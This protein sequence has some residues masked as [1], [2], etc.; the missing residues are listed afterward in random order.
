ME[1]YNPTTKSIY[2]FLIQYP[3][4]YQIILYMKIFPFASLA[5]L[6]LLPFLTAATCDLKCYFDQYCDDSYNP[7]WLLAL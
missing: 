1:M 6:A 3:I 5:L 2:Y 7:L 4:I